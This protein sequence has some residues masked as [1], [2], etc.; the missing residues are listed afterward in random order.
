MDSFRFFPPAILTLTSIHMVVAL[1]RPQ[2]EETGTSAPETSGS[3]RFSPSQNP[4]SSSQNQGSSPQTQTRFFPGFPGFQAPSLPQTNPNQGLQ[5]G[6]AAG[7][8]GAIGGIAATNCLF[9]RNCDLSFRPS[10]GGAVDA[11]GQFVPQ[12]GITTQV[13]D[14]S[15]GIGTT[16]TGGLQLDQ[17]SQNGLGGFVAGGINN[18]DPNQIG[19]G[20]QTGFG[21]SQQANG[22]TVATAQAGANVQAPTFGGVAFNRPNR[23]FG[24]QP[25]LGNRPTPPRPQQ[26]GF[27]QQQNGFNQQQS[28]FNRPPN[29]FNQPQ[30]GFNRPQNGFNQQGGFNQQTGF[31]QQQ[32]GFNRPQNNQQPGGF[33]L[34]NLF[35]GR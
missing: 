21:F 20:A 8:L 23:P 25:F 17:N 5:N 22:Q 27:N 34:F 6:L 35:G 10:F 28:G 12:V 7:G 14:G 11:N 1:P 16:F 30:S 32:G 31:N 26:N 15:G 4:D 24:A 33:N 9:G 19:V 18:G 13:G 29:G 3:V 2:F